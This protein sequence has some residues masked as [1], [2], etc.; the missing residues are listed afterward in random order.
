MAGPDETILPGQRL[1]AR[2]A[3][4]NRSGRFEAA[5]RVAVVDGWDLT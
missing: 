5:A 4:S 2:G 3:H 1:R